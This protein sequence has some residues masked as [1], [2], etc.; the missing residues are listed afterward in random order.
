MERNKNTQEDDSSFP[1][2][3]NT[4]NINFQRAE[5]D[6]PRVPR[7]LVMMMVCLKMRS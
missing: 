7:K 3:E 6:R 1:L 2:Q 4:L 5:L